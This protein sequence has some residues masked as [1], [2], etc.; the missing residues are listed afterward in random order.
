MLP[1]WG[2]LYSKHHDML[3][4]IFPLIAQDKY[5]QEAIKSDKRGI[6]CLDSLRKFD[7]CQRHC[8]RIEI[9]LKLK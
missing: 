7:F 4:R 3:I 5:A 6:F 1:R 8:L 2:K 9:R